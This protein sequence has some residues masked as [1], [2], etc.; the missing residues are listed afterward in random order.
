MKKLGWFGNQAIEFAS[1]Q[2]A[3]ARLIA[4]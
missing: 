4:L 3:S 1:V 2:E